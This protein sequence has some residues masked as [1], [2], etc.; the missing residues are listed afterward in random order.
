MKHKLGA[1]LYTRK[2]EANKTFNN[3]VLS[4]LSM[5]YP[6]YTNV[7]GV[8]TAFDEIPHSFKLNRTKKLAL[9]KGVGHGGVKLAYS[10]PRKVGRW[11][12]ELLQDSLLLLR[13]ILKVQKCEPLFVLVCFFIQNRESGTSTYMSGN[14]VYRELGNDTSVYRRSRTR[15]V[16]LVSSLSLGSNENV[17]GL[18]GTSE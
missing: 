15:P 16:T 8:F 11:R 14:R 6:L 7:H 3:S 10:A 2:N 5:F 18:A 1:S 13:V 4:C 17:Q 9:G 12:R